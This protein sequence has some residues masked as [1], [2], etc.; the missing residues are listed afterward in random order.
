MS[1]R[2]QDFTI[3]TAVVNIGLGSFIV[4]VVDKRDFQ[5]IVIPSVAEESQLSQM[6]RPFGFAQG[7]IH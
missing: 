3:T 2:R 1:F 6:V 5:V 7:D 4:E